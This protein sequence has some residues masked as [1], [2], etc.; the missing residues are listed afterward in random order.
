MRIEDRIV[1]SAL[2]A[3]YGDAVGFIGE[4]ADPGTVRYRTGGS[5]RIEGAKSWPRRIGG[6]FGL[7]VSL[8]A[9]CYSDDTQ[10][11]L[12]T[13]RAIR[14]SGEFDVEAFAKVELPVWLSYAFGAGKSTR[15]AA[16]SLAQTSVTWATNFFDAEGVSYFRAGGNGAAMRIQPHVWSAKDWQRPEMFLRDVVRNAIVTHGD[17]RGIVGA[18]IHALFLADTLANGVIPELQ[19]WEELVEAASTVIDVIDGDL[20]LRDIWCP[21]WEQRTTCTLAAGVRETIA[22]CINYCRLISELVTED[23]EGSYAKAVDALGGLAPESRG[24]ATVTTLLAGLLA[25]LYRA[26]PREGILCAANV[27]GSDTDTI[28]SMG[29]AIMGAVCE[30]APV[31]EI[32]DQEYVEREA[33]R[34]ADV[35]NGTAQGSFKYPDLLRWAA[36]KTQLDTIGQSTNGEMVV[37]GLGSARAIGEPINPRASA[38]EVMQWVELSFGQLLLVRRRQPLPVIQMTTV[39]SKPAEQAPRHGGLLDSGSWREIGRPVKKPLSIDEASRQVIGSG[40]DPG[41]IGRFLLEFARR[42]NG[43]ELAIAFA[44]IVSKA[45]IARDQ[46]DHRRDRRKPNS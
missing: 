12:A 27:L 16:K 46:A 37:A 40:F 23:A 20:D 22:E 21:L 29:G 6:K 7:V 33:R 38:T 39:D 3:A 26:S 14:A 45:K 19:R 9:G 18:A 28:A 4:M 30:T 25:W 13:S 31:E 42:D 8:P 10:L 5:S 41:M 1:R 15:A 43:I 34:L 11:R 24:S 36:P 35:R 2:W 17:P 44:A 32:A